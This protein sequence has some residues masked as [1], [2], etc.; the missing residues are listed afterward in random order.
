MTLY[1][2][3]AL[4]CKEFSFSLKKK[5]KDEHSKGN[6]LTQ[7]HTNRIT[8]TFDSVASGHLAFILSFKTTKTNSL[9]IFISPPSKAGINR[10]EETET[11]R[12]WDER[13]GH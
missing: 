2:A 4:H 13:Q 5:K 8:G 10:Q 7:I 11:K 6:F 1:V 12:G 9:F 3:T